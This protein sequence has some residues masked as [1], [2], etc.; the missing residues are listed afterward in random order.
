MTMPI[1]TFFPRQADGLCLTFTSADLVDDLQAL[2]HAET[3]LL[4]HASAV[5]V[6]VCEG[7]RT[8]GVRTARQL[9][10]AD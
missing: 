3:V 8:L 5:E 7:D 10:L 6:T 9:S 2:A 1:Y 4:A